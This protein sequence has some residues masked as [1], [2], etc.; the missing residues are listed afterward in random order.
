MPGPNNRAVSSASASIPLAPTME[1]KSVATTKTNL[2]G[3]QRCVLRAASRS[4]NL[5]AW[6]LPRTL[7][8]NP[9]SAA[10]V[11]RGLLK[12][13]LIEERP[14]RGNDAVW[15]EAEDG[16]PVTLVI[17]KAGL[18]A[19]GM[20]PET[21]AGQKPGGNNPGQKADSEAESG[22]TAPASENQRRMP[23]AG[24]KLAMLVGLLAREEGATVGEMAVALGWQQ[25]T[26]RGVMSGALTTRFGLRIVS[27]KIEGRGRAY[28]AE[29]GPALGAEEVD[30]A[31]E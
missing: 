21:E 6:P 7:K 1:T 25:Q 13:G 29:G 17:T 22:P 31:G 28:R 30:N 10:I 9:G 16:R 12:K 20:L 24:S 15:R 14:A 23:R 4:A 18:A 2:T 27:E 11:V 19:V 3:N 26:I 8:L 5:N